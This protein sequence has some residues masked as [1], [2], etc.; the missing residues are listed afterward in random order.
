MHLG[1]PGPV[2]ASTCCHAL[3][4]Q[5]LLS[6]LKNIPI[7]TLQSPWAHGVFRCC[8]GVGAGKARLAS[9]IMKA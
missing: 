1:L 5:C 4:I 2:L 7:G 6:T 3:I 8:A 9:E